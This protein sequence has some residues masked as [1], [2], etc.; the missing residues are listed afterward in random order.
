MD[1]HMVSSDGRIQPLRHDIIDENHKGLTFWVDKH[2]RYADREVEDMLA[3]E[4]DRRRIEVKGQAG[5]RRWL[6]ANVYARTPLFLRAI[7]YWF[8]RYVLKLGFLDGLPGLVF[9]FNQGLWYRFLVDA[10]LHELRAKR[11]LGTREPGR[12]SSEVTPP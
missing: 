11:H 6:K 1:E 4:A 12:G 5:Q 10:K 2:N 3:I 7:A 9:H 8:F